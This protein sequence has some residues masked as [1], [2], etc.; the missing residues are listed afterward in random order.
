MTATFH[1]LSSTGNSKRLTVSIFYRR[2]L[3]WHFGIRAELISVLAS[4][5]GNDYVSSDALA[6]FNLAL[7][8]LQTS[9]RFGRRGARFISIAN[10]LSELPDASTE[11]EALNSALQMVSSPES[12]TQLR[13]AV[14]L[15]LQEYTITESNLLPYFQGRCDLQLP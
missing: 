7:K 14:E 8:R 10:M 15:S 1:L 6:A 5:A 3:A 13:Q 2:K 12:R 11:E 9:S 4:L